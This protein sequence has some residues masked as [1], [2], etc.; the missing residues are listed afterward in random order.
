MNNNNIHHHRFSSPRRRNAVIELARMEE[1]AGNT[2]TLI[3]PSNRLSA[4]RGH[5]WLV[6]VLPLIS[7]LCLASY[8]V[9]P[10]LVWILTNVLNLTYLESFNGIVYD[11]IP[12]FAAA[13]A[14]LHVALCIGYASICG[15]R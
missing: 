14:L 4:R 2:V 5:T 9:A 6:G 12:Q 13:G 8:T 1:S 11:D 7:G 15:S 3:V 10:T